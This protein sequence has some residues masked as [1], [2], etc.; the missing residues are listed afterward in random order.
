MVNHYFK[1]LGLPPNASIEE[2]K[3]EFRLKAKQFHPDLNNSVFA[4]DKFIE[5][6]EAYEYLIKYFD[7]VK[8]QKFAKKTDNSQWI[9]EQRKKA[10]A[11]A[12]YYAK[13]RYEDF[14][15]SKVYKSANLVYSFFDF[16]YMIVGML[17]ISI[18]F[19]ISL[20]DLELEG[21]I[22]TV[23]AAVIA[24]LFGFMLAGATLYSLIRRWM[25]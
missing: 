2:V 10:R 4:K 7:I 21:K 14:E 19:F 5:V 11:R 1:I 17:M 22:A 20:E 6:N 15:K 25:K 23:I 16:L 12:A 9:Y 18:P 24:V 13:K 8:D 3:K